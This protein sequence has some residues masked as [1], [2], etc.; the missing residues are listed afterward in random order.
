MPYEDE[1]L[2]HGRLQEPPP[3]LDELARAVIGAAIEVH[4]R[5]SAGL[6]EAA[7]EGALAVELTERGI[8]FE[9]QVI[10]DIVYKGVVVA[11]G[12]IDMLVG[13]K[14]IVE[15]KSCESIRPVQRLQVRSYPRIINQPLGLLIN[16]NVA[17]LKDGIKRIICTG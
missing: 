3:E 5:L 11:K 2:M 14:L 6:P 15:N 9:R 13:G 7:Y 16:Y 1:D 17:M 12:R 8:P 10:V 4:R